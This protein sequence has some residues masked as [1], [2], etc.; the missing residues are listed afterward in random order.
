MLRLFLAI[1]LCLCAILLPF[2]AAHAQVYVS[3]PAYPPGPP[4]QGV[5]PVQ[6]PPPA[7]AYV[8]RPVPGSYASAPD[9]NNCG[10]P[11]EPKP[12]PPL[13]RV[14]LPYYPANR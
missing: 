3:P 11:D 9:S 10:T 13:P 5:Y 14:A 4:P 2:G 6:P 12:C 1:P 7:P 8:G